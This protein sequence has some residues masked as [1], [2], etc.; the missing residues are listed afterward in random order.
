MRR[1]TVAIAPTLS[2][3]ATAYMIVS[4]DS[5]RPTVAT[6]SG[7]EA[8]D[9]EDVDDG[10]HRFERKLEHHRNRQQDDRAADRTFGVVVVGAGQRFADRLQRLDLGTRRCVSVTAG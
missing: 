8:R 5:V 4:I 10:E 2:P 1:A 3:I 6:A 7:P 9:E